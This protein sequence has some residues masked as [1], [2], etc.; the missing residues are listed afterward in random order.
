MSSTPLIEPLLQVLQ[1]AGIWFSS[2]AAL[3]F[4]LYLVVAFR[5]CPALFRT[6]PAGP[7]PVKNEL[8]VNRPTAA[9]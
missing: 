3:G 4:V 1:I 9:D 7:L 5:E 8:E 6:R 2:A